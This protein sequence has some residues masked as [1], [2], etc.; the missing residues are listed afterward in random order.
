[1]YGGG[2]ARPAE[3]LS[4]LAQQYQ[5]RYFEH[6]NT[7]KNGRL[8]DIEGAHLFE[9][10]LAKVDAFHL[11]AKAALQIEHHAVGAAAHR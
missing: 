5:E 11:V 1:M 10:R 3:P 7:N 4:A 8:I 9:F 6:A 2:G